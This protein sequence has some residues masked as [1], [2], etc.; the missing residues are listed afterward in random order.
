MTTLTTEELATIT[1]KSGSHATREE[2]V[3]AMEAVAW[4]AGEPHS[5]APKCASPVIGGFLRSWNDALPTDE[6]RQR[7]LLPLLPLAVSTRADDDTELM[8]SYMALDWLVR[9]HGATW[10]QLAGLDDYAKAL[11]GLDEIDSPMAVEKAVP[12]LDAARAVV[13][14]AVGTAAGD[15]ARAVV[16]E[17]VGTAAG[18]AA[19]TAAW[20]AT[21]EGAVA[22]TWEGAGAAAKETA[23]DAARGVADAAWEATREAAG[24]VAWDAAR[25]AA[26]K[27]AWDAA[28]EALALTVA[29][30]QDS[31]QDLVRRMVVAK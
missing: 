23:W 8:R 26:G 15:A 1:L 22:A 21:W 31:A 24:K 2:G 16:R 7:L 17:A 10:M 25:E 11:S 19:R 29:E 9:V 30:L 14:E 28:R 5:A 3:C 27:V 20:A 6:S 18:A 13:R 4:L 12:L